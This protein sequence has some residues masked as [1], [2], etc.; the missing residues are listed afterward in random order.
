MA[1]LAFDIGGTAVK[2]GIWLE[3]QL[4]QAA[5]FATPDSWQGMQE[6]LVKV[7]RTAA[8]QHEITGVAIS[9]PGAVD[10]EKGV[11]GG[12]SAV[13]YIHQ[14]PIAAALQELFQLPVSIENDANCAALAEVWQGAAQEVQNS[15]F[16]IIG[17]GIGGAVVLNRK[18]HK[19]PQLFGG[20]FGYMLM[21]Q[22][23]T[24]SELASPVTTAQRF[25]QSHLGNP[26]L[27][28]KELFE[29]AEA[30]N[31]QAQEAVDRMY[32]A[33][34]RGIVNLSVSFN[35]D[36]V[37][38]GGGLSRR[39][40]LVEVLTEKVQQLLKQVGATDLVIPIEICQFNNQANLVG[41]VVHFD[42]TIK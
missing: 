40:D 17:S 4:I 38:I 8:Q 30:G 2:H 6:A 19:G 33:L 12:I 23:Q 42:Q 5:D 29:L 16:F 10:T 20:E 25:G 7:L 41:A 14:F 36:K 1:I 28:G 31:G 21:D 18:L 9:A 15:L 27:T 39:P 34:A 26:E 24:L 32:G 3:D 35:P 37:L 11:I 22:H 13:P